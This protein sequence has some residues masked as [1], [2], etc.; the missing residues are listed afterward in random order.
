MTKTALYAVIAN[1]SLAQSIQDNVS[2]DYVLSIDRTIEDIVVRMAESKPDIILCDQLLLE[3]TQSVVLATLKTACPTARILAIGPSRPIEIQVAALKHGARG[4]FD[5]SLPLQTLNAAFAGIMRGEVWV[6]RH[7]ISG[8]IDE[9]VLIPE[10]S[11]QQRKTVESLS[12]KELEVAKLVSHGAT[13]KMIAHQMLI[14]ERTVK[15]HLT[16]T[17]QKMNLPDRLSL[18]IFF[19]DLR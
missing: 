6:E 12:P 4:Y 8:L 18:A 17:F 1:Q 2:A 3:S 5:V 10:V 11:E 13:N 7:V 19:R 9:L 15:A 16:A 14:T